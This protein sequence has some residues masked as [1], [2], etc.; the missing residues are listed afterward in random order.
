MIGR[1]IANEI[2]VKNL[3]AYGDSKLIVNQVCGGYEVRHEDLVPYH[4]TT[5]HMAEKFRNFYI[6][7]VPR[8]QN[9]HADAPTSL[10]ASLALPAGVPEKVLVY[11][12]DL[13][14]PKLTLKKDQIPA[15]NLQVK[16]TLETSAGLELWDWRFSFI[17]Y[18]L[19]DILPDDPKEAAAI[20]RKAPKLYY[21]VITRTLYR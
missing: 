8:Q 9:A 10:A 15:G 21:N 13:Y 1:Q 4:N 14:Y 3:K 20:K 17:D 7:H 18:A 6:D 12:H 11:S 19:Y 5:I 2:G 16:E